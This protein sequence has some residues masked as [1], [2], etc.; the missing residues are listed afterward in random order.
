MRRAHAVVVLRYALAAALAAIA[1]PFIAHAAFGDDTLA[2]P[3]AQVFPTRTGIGVT[4]NPVDASTYR[5]ERKQGETDWQDASGDLASSTTSW[6]DESLGA[7]ASADYR[8]V[9]QTSD[10]ESVTSSSVTATRT[11]TAPVVGDVDVLALN[12]A[13]TDLVT[14]LRDESA[15]PVTASAPIGGSR[16]LSAGSIKLKL[17]AFLAG[18][19]TYELTP[20][21]IELTQGDR[22]CTTSGRLRVTALAYR[23]DLELETMAASLLVYSCAGTD[24]TAAIEIRFKSSIGYQMLSVT[25]NPLDAGQVLVGKTSAALPITVRNTGGEPVE[26]ERVELDWNASPEWKVASNNC[27][28]SLPAAASCTVT[29]TF[30]PWTHGLFQATLTIYNS[31]ALRE[32]VALTGNGTSLPRPMGVSVSPTFTGHTVRWLSW[33]TSGGTTTRGYFLHRYV[34][35]LETTRWFPGDPRATWFST[36]DA[37]PKPGTEYAVSVVNEVGEGPVGPRTAAPRPTDQI[38]IVQGEPAAAELAAADLG[39]N[40]VPFPGEAGSVKPKEA[41]ASAPDGRTLAYVTNDQERVL[42]TRQVDPDQLGVPVKLWASPLPITHLSWSPDGSRIAYQAPESGDDGALPCVF[43]IPA[44]GGTPEKISCDVANPSWMP[45]ALTLMVVD[46]RLDGDDRFARIEAKPGGARV[47]MLPAPAGDSASVR[48]SPDGQWV[49]FATKSNVALTNRWS[50][51][52]RL[53]PALD[54]EVRSINWAP[55]G[56]RLLALTSSGR[57]TR[58]PVSP[59]GEMTEWPPSVLGSTGSGATLDMAWQRL[60][61]TIKPTPAVMGPQV[62]IS[63]DSSALPVGTTFTCEFQGTGRPAAACVSPVTASGLPSWEHTLLI[64][65]KEPSGHVTTAVRTFTVDATG[66]T[67]RVVA[68]TYDASTAASATVQVAASDHS[69]VASYDVRYRKA[70]YLSGFGAYVQ[71]WTATTATSVSLPLDAGYEYCTSVRAKDKLGNVGAW[72]AEKCFSRPMDDRALAAPTAGWTR[73]SW[74]AFYL[75]TATQ[76]T[77]YGASLTR[78][79]QGKRFYLVATKCPTC[80]LV[81]VYAGG[82]YIGAVN[83]AAA[84]TQRQAVI[85]LPVQSTVFSGTLTFTVRSATGKFVQ[86]DGLAVRRS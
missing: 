43:V 40:I 69:G 5:V 58:L 29:L 19:G 44:A 31:A 21:Q 25:P 27:P 34:D 79:V 14:W 76:S 2:T 66:P 30:E 8:V 4:W 50:A 18:P 57:M 73:T 49:A 81:A 67:A 41:I 13:A 7:G 39:G 36:T 15:S 6:V 26:I 62:S 3:S 71:P 72:S 33:P 70:S 46:R 75:G 54:G 32:E 47:S 77:S 1:V 24:T 85:P 20:S 61:V 78:T 55:G 74:S 80:G 52:V 45:D 65:A 37:N 84:T 59:L 11:T 86:I 63:F 23:A 56:D 9:A 17:P 16:T 22:S 35:G 42:W 53:S 28:V 38:A 12:A 10:T 82:K 60:G 83:L 68:P 48:V 51:E 64:T